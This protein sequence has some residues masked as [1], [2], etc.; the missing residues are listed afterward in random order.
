M[1]SKSKVGQPGVLNCILACALLNFLATPVSMAED[2]EIR[3]V[4]H[5][6]Y[7]SMFFEPGFLAIQ[8][9]DRVTFLVSDLDH[10]PQ[11]VFAPAG[12]DHWQAE[13]GQTTTVTFEREGVYIFDCAYHNVMGM[14]GVVL[15]GRPVNLEEARAFF[16]AY[17]ERTFAMNKDRLDP[18]WSSNGEYL[19]GKPAK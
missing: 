17:R 3:A 6:G 4:T 18:V 2:Y 14:A 19:S 13:K 15:V 7:E 8:P 9:G 1:M 10:Q 16:E 12:A 11:S 5:R